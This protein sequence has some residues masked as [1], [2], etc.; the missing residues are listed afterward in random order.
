MNG[1]SDGW[2]GMVVAVALIAVACLIGFLVRRQQA[3]KPVFA[4]PDVTESANRVL[5]EIHLASSDELSVVNK[6]D[7][8]E[9]RSSDLEN[10][11][12]AEEALSRLR[13][14]GRP[15]T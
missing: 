8:D 11:A 6:E 15:K 4:R 5:S 13:Q 12:A 14:N 7:V 9:S 3:K 2:F 10:A 1:L